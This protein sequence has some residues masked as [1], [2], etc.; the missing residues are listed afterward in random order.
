MNQSDEK[1]APYP[2]WSEAAETGHFVH[3][4]ENEAFLIDSVSG[5]IGTALVTGAGGLVIATA[6]HRDGIQ[7]ELEA[8]GMNVRRRRSPG[9]IRGGWT[10]QNS[11]RSSWLTGR[12]TRFDLPRWSAA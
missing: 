4:F 12:P 5:F 7:K 6:A 9:A 10:P 1:L 8:R 3:F 2:D 11:Y